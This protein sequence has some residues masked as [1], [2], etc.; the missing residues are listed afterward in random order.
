MT[1]EPLFLT[2]ETYLGKVINMKKKRIT[3]IVCLATILLAACAPSPQTIQTAIAQTQAA[4]PTS[5]FTLVPPTDTPTE[6]PSE[7]STITI[8]LSPTLDLLVLQLNLKDFLLQQSDIPLNAHYSSIVNSV[9]STPNEKVDSTYVEQTGRID[10]WSVW[11][12]KGTNNNWQE[13]ISDEV[14]L[15]QTTAGAQLAITNYSESGSTEEINPP[16]IGDKTRAFYSRLPYS[17]G[18]PQG[19]YEIDFSYK[20]CVHAVQG[21]GLDNEI[22]EFTR[23]I[24]RILLAKLQ[25]SP[26][27]NP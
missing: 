18:E 25:A 22:A 5:T 21:F 6:T 20:N 9:N 26:L 11:Y 23:N 7:T 8:M 2:V 3:I 1:A 19:I 17:G 27:I 4:N 10:G 15:Y 13:T 12:G 24:A 14:V 16:E